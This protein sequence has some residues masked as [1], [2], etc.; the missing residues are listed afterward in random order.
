[1]ISS[2]RKQA[3]PLISWFGPLC[4][5]LATILFNKPIHAQ[6][7]IVLEPSQQSYPLNRYMGHLEDRAGTLSIA[8]VAAAPR[9]AF[10]FP[11]QDVTNFGFT[12][13]AYWI[14][15]E[16]RSTALAPTQ[17]LLEVL[18]AHV[19]R[20][21]VYL[22]HA[23]GRI[24]SAHGGDALPFS[25]RSKKHRFPMF[26]I[27]LPA[28][29]EATLFLRAS[30]EGALHLPLILR[31]PAHLMARDHD[32]QF[33][34]GLYYGIL[35]AMFIY[36]TMLFASVRDRSYLYYSLY[37]GAWS[38]MQMG[39][40]GLAFEYLWPNSP[41]WANIAVPF[42]VGVNICMTT[43]FSKS[44]LQIEVIAPGLTRYFN[45]FVVL[46]LAVM[47]GV[48]VLP[49]T[50][51]TKIAQGG[52]LAECA[53]VLAAGAYCLRRGG[54]QARYFMLAWSVL[55]L[56]A[57]MYVMQNSGMIQSVFITEYGLQI[58]SAVEV[59]LFSLALAHRL[60][61]LQD[62]N[63]RI[64]R[65]AAE[66]LEE[67]V[68]QRTLELD[69]ALAHL[70]E[71][72]Q[73]LTE[74]SKNDGLTG[75][76]NR[77]TFNER[78]AAEWQRGT[79]E[80]KSICVLMVDIDH[81]KRINDTHGHLIGDVCLKAVASA[82]AAQIHRSGDAVFRFGGEE[83]ALLLPNTDLEGAAFLAEQARHSIEQLNLAPNGQP[84]PMTV[85]IGVACLLPA[86]EASYDAL[87]DTADKALYRA[88]H[89]GRNRV[90]L[91]SRPS[92]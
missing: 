78:I 58:G 37:I 86:S 21:D 79:R 31:T 61:V 53:F 42:F 65:E 54:M 59:L 62:E 47:A 1:M 45:G 16:L 80:K 44:F 7:R 69:G 28:N 92:A 51:A 77:A 52:A 30:S 76:R 33:I 82:L 90:C 11:A 68:K 41:H 12:K 89:E 50:S 60:K 71:A 20:L 23:D 40:N 14:R 48:F 5:L 49:Y 63:I 39:L 46:G 6:E 72:H 13:S 74:V 26:D 2:S 4:V 8:D 64:Q 73:Q 66:L 22:V 43:L 3:T 91:G 24:D 67:R 34:L 36:N 19:D 25:A 10:S 35:L 75:V 55:L 81:F 27:A 17:W 88:K 18:Y 57:I 83:F 56:G 38:L 87:L 84:I 70:S 85:S 29:S 15:I 9:D 32:E